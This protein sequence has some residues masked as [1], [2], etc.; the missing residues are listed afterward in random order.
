MTHTKKM[1][2]HRARLFYYAWTFGGKQRAI[3]DKKYK[4][5]DQNYAIKSNHIRNRTGFVEYQ[6]H[7]LHWKNN[8]H[9]KI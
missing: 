8:N 1:Q 9:Q 4:N 7:F 6:D 5:I 3:H 2:E